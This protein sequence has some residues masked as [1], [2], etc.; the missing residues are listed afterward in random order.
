Y[1]QSQSDARSF[2]PVVGAL[3][4]SAHTENTT[5]LV[6]FD[7]HGVLTSYQATQGGSTLGTGLI[8]GQKQ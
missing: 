1:F 8:S 2:I 3:V 5:V 7:R 6:L 4:G